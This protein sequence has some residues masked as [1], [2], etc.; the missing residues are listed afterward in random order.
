MTCGS[1]YSPSVNDLNGVCKKDQIDHKLQKLGPCWTFRKN[2]DQTK[3][4]SRK[5]GPTRY[6]SLERKI[7]KHTYFYN[8]LWVIQSSKI[9]QKS[10]NWIWWTKTC[11]FQP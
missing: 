4:N 11:L 6:L 2:E 1:Y 8:F 7:K 9:K 3:Q 10:K 5:L